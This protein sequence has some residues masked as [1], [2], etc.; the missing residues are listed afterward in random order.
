LSAEIAA[1]VQG[2]W[3]KAGYGPPPPQTPCDEMATGRIGAID[4]SRG[5]FSFFEVWTMAAHEIARTG[6]A[7]QA[8]DAL[9]SGV[10]VRALLPTMYGVTAGPEVDPASERR[11]F[12]RTLRRAERAKSNRPG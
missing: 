9:L 2:L 1:L 4:L 8:E 11:V 3:I 6:R 5:C 12:I 7:R 10:T